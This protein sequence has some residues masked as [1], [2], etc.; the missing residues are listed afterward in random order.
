LPSRSKKPKVGN[1]SKMEV[2]TVLK[3]MDDAITAT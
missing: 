2:H 3:L 1:G